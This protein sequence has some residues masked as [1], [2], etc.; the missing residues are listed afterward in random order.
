MP[1]LPCPETDS[2]G[3]VPGFLR[4]KPAKCLTKSLGR[5]R[6][7]WGNSFLGPRGLWRLCEASHFSK[8]EFSDLGRTANPG[9]AHP[10]L[11]MFLVFPRCLH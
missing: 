3:A 10:P 9:A 4:G 7:L 1:P 6:R 2:A 11:P 8:D 5:R